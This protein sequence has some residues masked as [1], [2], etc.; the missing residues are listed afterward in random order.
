MGVSALVEGQ[1]AGQLQT[2]EPN[3]AGGVPRG[4][5][6]WGVMGTTCTDVVG[7]VAGPQMA[8]GICFLFSIRRVGGGGS[9]IGLTCLRL[10]CM[11]T[12][13][14]VGCACKRQLCPVAVAACA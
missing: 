9:Q 7:R 4:G 1:V 6:A 5:T 3:S 13:D 12:E 10:W 2:L 8:K 11:G 14:C